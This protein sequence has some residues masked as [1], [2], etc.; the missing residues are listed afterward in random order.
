MSSAVH[1]V[2]PGD[3][4]SSIAQHYG[5]PAQ[6][7]WDLRLRVLDDGKP[8][9]N[10][11]YILAIGSDRIEGQTDPDGLVNEKVPPGETRAVLRLGRGL[12]ATDY[13]L[14]LGHLDPFDEITGGQARLK[15]LGYY[16]GTVDG[17]LG[18][19]TTQA[20]RQFQHDRSLEVTGRFDERTLEALKAEH[21]S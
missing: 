10:E 21:G 19:L 12:D 18:K 1:Y 9:A 15:N 7:I 8:R 11:P 4:L 16:A 14:N 13:V 3:C 5:M 2:Q 20:L 17:V 6:L